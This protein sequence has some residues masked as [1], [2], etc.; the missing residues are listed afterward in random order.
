MSKRL[1][2]F[3]A[4]TLCLLVWSCSGFAT[5]EDIH[6]DKPDDSSTKSRFIPVEL[7]TGIKW[8]GEHKLILKEASTS[9]SACD[10]VSG[11]RCTTY[12]ISGP[13]KTERNDTK[14][15]WAG[16]EIP[17]YLRTFR[18][19]RFGDV[20]SF[21]TIN[22]SR[23]GLVRIF[24]KRKQWG[25]RTYSGLGNKFPLGYWTQGEVRTY[26]TRRPIRVE[27]IELDGPNHCLTFRWTI[28][29][30]PIFSRNSDNNY[31]YCP[32]IGLKSM[33]HNS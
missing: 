14:I 22:N 8:D 16:D 26:P 20:E 23:D 15:E 10:S 31:T 1:K 6:Q 25:A 24:D 7:F 30:G 9:T 28:G 19:R 17:Y 21:F 33:Q 12:N 27:I 4:T 18:T 5:E 13:F 3:S 2:L 32:G 29:E 11:K